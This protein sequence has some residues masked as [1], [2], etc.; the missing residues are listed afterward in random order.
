LGRK[1]IEALLAEENIRVA[2]DGGGRLAFHD[3][4][5]LGRYNNEYEA[6]R[7]AAA[8]TGMTLVELAQSRDKVL[9]CSG[10]GARVPMDAPWASRIWRSG[11]SRRS[12]RMGW[13][14]ADTSCM[15]ELAGRVARLHGCRRR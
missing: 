10:G 1:Y 13:S 2:K 5:Y 9:C 7:C 3:S 8:S 15:I 6:P 14:P 12:W 4:C 11:M